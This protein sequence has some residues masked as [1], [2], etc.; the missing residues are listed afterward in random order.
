MSPQHDQ[1]LQRGFLGWPAWVWAAVA[2]ALGLVLSTV[3]TGLHARSLERE[4]HA[5]LERVAE[6]TFDA[7]AAQLETCGL[8]VRSL[9]ALFLSSDDV[10]EDEFGAMYANLRP[11]DLFPSLQAVAYAVRQVGEDGEPHYPTV[12]LEPRSGNE[13]LRGFD[14][15]RQPANLAAALFAR[16]ADRPVMSAPF[17][18]V[19]RADAPGPRDGITI[20]LPVFSAGLLPRDVGER[21]ARE[22]GSL[23]VSFRVSTLI[24]GAL[25]DESRETFDLRVTDVTEAA[26][27]VLFGEDVGDHDH[28]GTVFVREIAYGTRNWRIEAWPRLASGDTRWSPL[29]TFALGLLGSGLLAALVWSMAGTRQRAL[30][31]AEGMSAR[32]RES[33]ERF[34]ALNDLLPALVLLADSASGRVVYANQACRDRFA[35]DTGDEL[36][37]ADIVEDADLRERLRALGSGDG[38][39]VNESAA[40]R[41]SGG[42][43]PFWATLSV[44]RIEFDGRPHLLAVANDTTELRVLSEELSWQSSHDVLTGLENRREFERRLHRAIVA[45]D[46]GAAPGALIYLDLDQFKLVNDTSGHYAGDQLLAQLGSIITGVLP[47]SATLARLGGDEFAVLVPAI[48]AEGATALAERIRVEIDGFVFGWEERNYT[49]TA[50]VGVVLLDGPGLSLRKVLAQADTACYMAKERGRNRVHVFSDTD[51][52][53]ARRRSEM[54]WAGKVRE[55][56]SEGRFELHYQELAPLWHREGADGVHMEM[57][58]RMRDEAGAMVP[59]GAFIPAAERFGLMP[60]L[61]RWVVDTTLANFGRLHASGK[62]PRLCAINLSGPTFEDDSFADF[63]L[64]RLEEY[65]VPPSRICFEITETAAVSNMTRAIAFMQRLRGAGCRFSLDDFGSGMASF[66]YLKNLPVDYLKI[67][68]SFIRNLENDPVSYSIVRAVTDIGHQLGL[69]VIAEWVADDKARDLLRGLS[70]DYAQGFAIH[71]PERAACFGP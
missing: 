8:L 6:R 23:A 24:A 40:L 60:L 56:L 65:D 55:A 11:R 18:L 59:P 25:P 47:E 50:S 28:D 10:T 30:A 48:D 9:Q 57:L 64:Q 21:R 41:G 29:L 27:K 33:E 54:E 2:F 22:I 51:S 61:D 17:A 44:T 66:G 35:I 32:F 62:P 14:V 1:R 49:T 16:D 4:E 71:K 52:E 38:D 37:L 13:S 46:A 68:G 70:V 63:V 20:R 43:D 7:L 34:R 42:A 19:Q 5:R 26:P 45:L 31:L 67:D 12:L 3:L 53:T 58:I 69:Q 36:V 39:L 15:A